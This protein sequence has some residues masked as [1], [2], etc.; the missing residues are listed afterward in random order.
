M[1]RRCSLV[2]TALFALVLVAGCDSAP[3]HDS[4]MEESVSSMEEMVAIMKTIKDKPSAEAAKPK[5]EALGDRMKELKAE[6]DKL[7]KPSKEKEAELKKKYDDRMQKVF[8]ELMGEGMRIGMN[9]ELKDVMK[10][11]KMDGAK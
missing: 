3:T 10:D 11:V 5:L 8:A 7:G 9:P 2:S 1:F 4:V 6:A